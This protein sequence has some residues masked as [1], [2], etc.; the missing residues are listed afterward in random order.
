MSE[1]ER[2]ENLCCESSHK[3]MTSEIKHY[4]DHTED[5]DSR[6]TLVEKFVTKTQ[7]VI[8]VVK[9]LGLA[10]AVGITA[11]LLDKFGSA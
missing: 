4:I 10:N 2:N 3:V 9:W 1:Q 6:L 7:G 5:I 8:D 11:F